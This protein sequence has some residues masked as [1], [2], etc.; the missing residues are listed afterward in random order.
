MQKYWLI[1][2]FKETRFDSSISDNI[3]HLNDCDIIIEKTKTDQEI[4]VE[5]VST[6]VVT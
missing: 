5:Y 6:C 3:L 2:A 1:V 4:G